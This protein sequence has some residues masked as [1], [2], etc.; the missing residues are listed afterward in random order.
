M[1]SRTL[2]PFLL[3][4]F[5]GTAVPAQQPGATVPAPLAP[6]LFREFHWRNIGPFRAGRTRASAG[7]PA[8]PFTFYVG[9]VNGG[10]WQTTDAGRTWRSIF[11]DQPTQSVGAV[12][13]APSI[14]YIIYVGSGEGLQ[15]PDL[16]VGDGVY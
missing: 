6:E 3:I 2:L 8:R 14:P 11:D 15:R 10:V 13:V 7:H 5:T 1:S 9:V 4:A 12:V 16:S